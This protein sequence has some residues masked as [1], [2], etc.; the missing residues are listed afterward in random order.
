MVIAAASYAYTI[1]PVA[2]VVVGVVLAAAMAAAYFVSIQQK[3]SRMLPFFFFSG[4]FATV[5]SAIAVHSTLTQHDPAFELARAP[6]RVSLQVL[7]RD[8][9]KKYT[10]TLVE[11]EVR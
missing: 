4:K 1:E 9:K 5:F 10:V 3:V 8:P 11:R 2:G 7:L 6:T